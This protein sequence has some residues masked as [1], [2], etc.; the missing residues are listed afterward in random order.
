MKTVLLIDDDRSTRLILS[1]VLKKAGWRVLEAGDGEVGLG[2]VEEHRPE[3]VVCD[4]HMPRCNG[5]QVCRQLR[6]R[7]DGLHQTKII[8]TTSSAYATDRVNAFEAGADEYLVK[9]LDPVEVVQMVERLVTANGSAEEAP[10]KAPA[11]TVPADHA[12]RPPTPHTPTSRKDKPVALKFWGVRGSIPTPGPTTAFFGGNTTCVEVQA[13][14]EI[15]VLDAG[16]GIRGLGLELISELKGEPMNLTVLITHT[17]WDHIQ[18]FPFFVPAYNPKNQI[19][20]LGYEGA[21]KGLES[22]L[23][24]QMESPYFPISMQQM[25]GNISI[26]ELKDLK[27]SVG[28]VNVQAQFM[29]HPGVCVGYRVTTSA[30]TIVF[31]P[32]NEPFTR[33]KSTS[34]GSSEKDAAALEYAKQQDQK[35]VDF[36]RDADVL[37]M[38]SQYDAMEYPRHVGWG[39]T[40]VDDSVAIALSAGVKRLFLFHHDPGHD[41]THVS[42]MVAWGRKIVARQGEKMTVEAARE[43]IEV[44]LTPAGK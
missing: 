25:P 7:L 37:I 1:K 34:T 38:D 22:T 6:E 16:T 30:G 31:I 26:Q 42:H 15:I 4:L 35:L 41:D 36:I 33:M 44:V 18:G 19:R 20:I 3:V 39:H 2:M 27:F 40:C 5:F 24:N 17:H 43:G 11:A 9:P 28:R 32:D 29:N 23:S 14:G 21:R 8:V 10:A 12:P 13:D